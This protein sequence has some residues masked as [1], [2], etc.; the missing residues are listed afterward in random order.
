VA[1]LLSQCIR[2][3]F[4]MLPL[5]FAGLPIYMHAPDFY[6]LEYKISLTTI[7]IVLLCLRI[8]DAVQDPLIGMLSDR[9]FRQR[10]LITLMGAILLALGFWLLFHP[11]NPTSHG[12]A[13]IWMSF[14]VVL[15]TTGFSIVTINVQSAGGLWAV[16]VQARTQVAAT[17]EALGLV[18]L[19]M[20]AA[21]P[22]LLFIQFSK[23]YALHLLSWLLF[24]LLAAGLWIFLHWL[25]H[26]Q[27]IKPNPR[28]QLS[29]AGLLSTPW[30]KHFF[31]IFT[32]S[33]FASC[34]PGILVIF[35]VRDYLQLESYT[36][37]FLLLYFIS[38]V[39]AMPL[40]QLMAQ[41]I[42]KHHSWTF[43]M[44]VACSTFSLAFLLPPNALVAFCL[45]CALSGMALGADLAL[46]QAI[47]ADQVAQQPEAAS[48]YFA[49]M[50]F[51]SKAA[52]ALATGIV[53]PLVGLFGFQPGSS[54]NNVVLPYAYALVPC[55]LKAAC[56][57]YFLYCCRRY[58][59]P[60]STPGRKISSLPATIS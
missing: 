44:L 6:A 41:T 38:G 19:L 1:G 39:L 8:F 48:R 37:L 47:I 18:G 36:G 58:Y 51:L 60:G 52:L 49:L 32:L 28:V 59:S 4:I 16:T 27:L 31:A 57:V 3:G 50:A 46:P 2:H 45:V 9:Y 5:A 22:S 55:C 20:A 10:G 56:A 25:K 29:L 54:E 11:P 21:I 33:T 15:S 35:Y 7:G 17:R 12:W 24:P 13:L 42:G 34:I 53:L 40:W 43:S 14:A 26:A 23:A 30:I